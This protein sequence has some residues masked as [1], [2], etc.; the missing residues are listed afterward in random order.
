MVHGLRY[1]SIVFLDELIYIYKSIYY[2][3]PLFFTIFIPI[4]FKKREFTV[5]RLPYDWYFVGGRGSEGFI[6]DINGML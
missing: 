6:V 2:I 4:P 1:G 5:Y 3:F